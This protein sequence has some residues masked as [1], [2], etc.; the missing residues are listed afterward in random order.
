MKLYSCGAVEKLINKYTAN[1]GEVHEIEPGCVGY[2]FTILH[3]ENLKTIVIKE[4]FVNCW[5]SA[6]TIRAYNKTP[7]K[8][9]K[10]IEKYKESQEAEQ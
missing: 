9:K 4:H 10:I 5:N 1:G 6:H 2:G 8:Y 3:G 7:K